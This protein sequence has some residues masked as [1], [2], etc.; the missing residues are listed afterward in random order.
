MKLKDFILVLAVL[1]V[2]SGCASVKYEYS[3][4]HENGAIKSKTK[5]RY[6]RTFN[7][8][9]EVGNLKTDLFEAH[10]EDQNADNSEITESISSGIV[11]G[12]GKVVTP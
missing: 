6:Y 4:Y 1:F 2:L 12:I 8:Q 5:A 7:Q 10:L 3:A 11:E 9:I